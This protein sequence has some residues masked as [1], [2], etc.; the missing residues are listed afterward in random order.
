MNFAIEGI[1]KMP[2]KKKIKYKNMDLLVT[3]AQ[4]HHSQKKEKLSQNNDIGYY[5]KS[6]FLTTYLIIFRQ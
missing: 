6:L 1:A 2:I 3:V 5:T 4:F